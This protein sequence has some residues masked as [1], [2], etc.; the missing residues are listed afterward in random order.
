MEQFTGAIRSCIDTNNW[1]GALFISL[2]VPDI[3]GNI[4]YPDLR[5]SNHTK[6]RYNRWVNEYLSQYLK[7][8][9]G[10]IPII[11]TA[12]DFYQIRC[13][14]LHE[15]IDE[16]YIFVIKDFHLVE[17]GSM[18]RVNIVRFCE[19]VLSAIERWSIDIENDQEAQRRLKILSRILSGEI[20]TYAP[21]VNITPT[22]KLESA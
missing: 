14:L 16:K 15:G 19:H 17:I 12:D 3:C 1:Y 7:N 21:T 2:S 8:E 6:E 18:I 20:I 10:K 4:T 22:S 9:H 5:G 13:H 11:M